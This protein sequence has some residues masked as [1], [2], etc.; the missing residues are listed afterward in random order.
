M[1][2]QLN[3]IIPQDELDEELTINLKK[4]FFSIYSKKI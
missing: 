3:Y 2:Q 1:Q 4:I